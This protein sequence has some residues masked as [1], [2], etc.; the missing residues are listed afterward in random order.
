M[1]WYYR[2]LPREQPRKATVGYRV[3]TSD[4]MV[5]AWRNPRVGDII[6]DGL[7]LRCGP[8]PLGS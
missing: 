7:R 5:P 6:A 8:W 3:G 4:R 2:H 1:N